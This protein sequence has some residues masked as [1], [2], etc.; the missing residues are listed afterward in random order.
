MRGVSLD[1]KMSSNSASI[2]SSGRPIH[3]GMV[4]G[5][6]GICLYRVLLQGNWNVLA[7]RVVHFLELSLLLDG[8]CR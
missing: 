6:N 8:V 7:G 3:S 1:L 2:I 4:G 5:K